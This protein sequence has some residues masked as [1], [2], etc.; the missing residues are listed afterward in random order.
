MT[1]LAQGGH[2]VSF[3]PVWSIEE[4]IKRIKNGELAAEA[5]AFDRLSPEVK[6]SLLKQWYETQVLPDGKRLEQ[7]TFW[8]MIGELIVSLLA[9]VANS[10]KDKSAEKK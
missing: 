4:R 7:M 6:S 8:E 3:N 5:S 9:S 10:R 2:K 1:T